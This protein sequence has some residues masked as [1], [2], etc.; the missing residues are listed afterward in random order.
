MQWQERC[1]VRKCETWYHQKCE[2]LTNL[3]FNFLLKTTLSYICSSCCLNSHG[4]FDFLAG[5]RRLSSHRCT[6]NAAYLESIFTRHL[7]AKMNPKPSLARQ[8]F[9]DELAQNFLGPKS[10]YFAVDTTGDGN[11]LFN[12]I[13]LA[14]DNTESYALELRYRTCLEMIRNKHFTLKRM[15]RTDL[16]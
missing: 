9:E 7:A 8:F 14:I 11:C 2:Q 3:Q 1:R 5:L 12:A 4:N 10:D 16:L 15:P 6:D 13:S